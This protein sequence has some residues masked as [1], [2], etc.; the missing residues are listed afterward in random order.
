MLE[1]NDKFRKLLNVCKWHE[2]GYTG[3]RGLTISG[4]NF[5]NRKAA[6]G[7]HYKT[8]FVFREIAPD[9]EVIYPLETGENVLGAENIEQM[10]Q[11]ASQTGADTFF[12]SYSGGENGKAYDA[13]IGRVERLTAFMSA[14]NDGANS[15]NPAI[16]SEHILGVGA[17]HLTADGRI[18]P[19]SYTSLSVDVDFCAPAKLYTDDGTP[20][21]GTSCAAPV[22]CG[23]AALV[24]DMFIDKT[25]APLTRE[26]MTRFLLDCSVDVGKTGKDDACGAGIPILPDPAEVDTRRYQNMYSSRDIDKLRP[27]VA[28]NCRKLIELAADRYPVLV[29]GT[30]RDEEYQRWCYENGTSQSAVPSFHSEKAGLA[31][32]VCKNIKGH[33]YDDNEFWKY[34]GALGKEIG[35]TWGGDWKSFV[36]KPHFQWDDGGKF[37]SSMVRAGKYPRP[38]PLY[39]KDEE[40][41]TREEVQKMIEEA[42][43]PV[44]K[45]LEDV[46]AWGQATVKKLVEKGALAGD[47]EGLN[48]SNSVLRVF[49][50]FDRMGAFNK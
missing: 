9:R 38:M 11:R 47:G 8:W 28:A 33:E 19:A 2:A 27:D 46:P 7:H 10:V 3:K 23:M 41:M 25:G 39:G 30:V 31:F 50:V 20:F 14:G 6:S 45:T 5:T 16:R 15:S 26:A 29:T 34:V 21:P 32:D 22:L 24:N 43:E 37:T 17:I 44:Y 35:F 18:A 36:D 1:A 42:Q 4:E 13:S 12:G 48:I 49:V 40:E